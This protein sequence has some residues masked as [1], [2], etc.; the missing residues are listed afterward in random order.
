VWSNACIR[1]VRFGLVEVALARFRY[2]DLSIVLACGDALVE[3]SIK[4]SEICEAIR[5]GLGG[6]TTAFD[7]HLN[8][9][10]FDSPAVL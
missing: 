2:A 7:V 10:Q 5:T 4:P 1:L 3:V 9:L 8:P 6:L